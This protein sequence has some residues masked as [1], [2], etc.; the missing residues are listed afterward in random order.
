MNKTSEN[1]SYLI[2]NKK[3]LCQHKKLYPLTARR[4]KW[5]PEILYR[6]IASIVKN[7]S[8]NCESF[9]TMLA[10]SL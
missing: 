1:M 8:P 4:V 2:D 9:F 7:D 6:D 10:I 5:I 3:F